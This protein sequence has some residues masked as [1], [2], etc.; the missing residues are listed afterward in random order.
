[1]K[2]RYFTEQDAET[3]TPVAI[4][5]ETFAQ[6]FWPNEDPIGKRLSFENEGGLESPK[7]NWREVVGVVSHVRHYNL[8]MQSRIEIYAPYQQ[9][10]LWSK[11]RRP[12]MD[13]G[14]APRPIRLR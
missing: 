6:R 1:M 14:C 4:I 8:E 12:P 5:D 3:S 7:P 10:P 9:L 13:W 11:K 2:G